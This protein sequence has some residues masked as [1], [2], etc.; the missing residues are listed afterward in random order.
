MAYS[1]FIVATATKCSNNFILFVCISLHGVYITH[2]EFREE[3]LIN[4]MHRFQLDAICESPYLI[5]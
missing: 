4:K 3:I 1:Y 2:R 5:F